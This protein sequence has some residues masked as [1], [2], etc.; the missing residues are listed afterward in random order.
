M[1]SVTHKKTIHLIQVAFLIFLSILF[2]KP[3]YVELTGD[4]TKYLVYGLNIH[5]GDGYTDVSG[6]PIGFRGPIFPF[7]LACSFKLLG[8]STESALYCVRSFFVFNLLL[9][10]FLARRLFGWST[11]WITIALYLFVFRVIAS[12]PHCRSCRHAFVSC[13]FARIR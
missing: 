9:L 1:T 4:S 8:V 6:T 3:A 7:L 2:F 11:A 12:P 5:N 13:K 10:F